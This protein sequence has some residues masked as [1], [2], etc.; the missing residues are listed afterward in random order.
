[1]NAASTPYGLVRALPERRKS[2]FASRV[3]LYRG[4]KPSSIALKLHARGAGR[5][6]DLAS[7]TS[8]RRRLF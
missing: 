8:G 4:N 1:M 7:G 3:L 5:G 6:P 2:V